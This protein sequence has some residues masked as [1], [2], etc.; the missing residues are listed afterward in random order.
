M[1][2]AKEIEY[3]CEVR[4]VHK[5]VQVRKATIILDDGEEISRNYQ[6]YVLKCRT[7]TGGT[8]E[9]TDLSGEDASIQRVCN[10]VWTNE[11]KTA[12]GRSVDE[13]GDLRAD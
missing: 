9:E 8:W 3:D 11:I 12:N 2:L 4:G 1:A 7:K 13:Q 10:A 6:R 5:S